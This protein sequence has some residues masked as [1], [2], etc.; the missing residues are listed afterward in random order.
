MTFFRV[1]SSKR[2]QEGDAFRFPVASTPFADATDPVFLATDP[3]TGSSIEG[4]QH[5][6]S[7]RGMG[8][9]RGQLNGL[10]IRSFSRFLIFVIFTHTWANDPI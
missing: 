10:V 6:G 9:V 4:L 2:L 7:G 5:L 8:E 1:R 3:P